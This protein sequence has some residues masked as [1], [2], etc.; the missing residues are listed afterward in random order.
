MHPRR[1]RRQRLDARWCEVRIASPAVG[2]VGGK[3][4]HRLEVEWA[5]IQLDPALVDL[6]RGGQRSSRLTRPR[7]WA[8]HDHVRPRQH[9]GQCCDLRQAALCQLALAVTEIQ[10][11]PIGFRLAMADEQQHATHRP[12]TQPSGPARTVRERPGRAAD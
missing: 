9:I 4:P 11:P 5:V 7:Q 1:E 3:L 6:D 8:R 12:S 10:A 2:Q